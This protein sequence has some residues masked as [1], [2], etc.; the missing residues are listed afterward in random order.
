MKK[1]VILLLLIIPVAYAQGITLGLRTYSPFF[2]SLLVLILLAA[3]TFL[4]IFI[5]DHLPKIKFAKLNFKKKKIKARVKE[6]IQEL[7]ETDYHKESLI[8]AKKLNTLSNETALKQLSGLIKEYT[9][10]IL[11]IKHEVTHEE[12]VKAVEKNKPQLKD[13]LS[14]ILEYKY[15]GEN[16]TKEE[17]KDLSDRFLEITKSS[18]PISVEKPEP[19]IE[20]IKQMLI[21]KQ[22]NFKEFLRLINEK[23]KPIKETPKSSKKQIQRFKL[24]FEEE[25]P[26]LLQFF[27]P[28]NIYFQK[29]K[30]NGLIQKA[31]K[32]LHQVP[33][34]KK[35][36]SQALMLYYQL[37][38]EQEKE[39]GITLV[40][41]YSKIE[42]EQ[43]DQESRKLEL[44]TSQL[45]QVT[46]K[47]GV[48]T[49][50][51]KHYLT[52]IRDSLSLFSNYKNQWL[53]NIHQAT[54]PHV[55]QIEHKWAHNIHD[56]E[57]QVANNIKNQIVRV[58][59]FKQKTHK[60][61][62][63]IKEILT[64]QTL[65]EK[66]K[67]KE[68]LF[69]IKNKLETLQKN[70]EKR[71]HIKFN[72]KLQKGKEKEQ[73]K[74][75][76]LKYPTLHEQKTLEKIHNSLEELKESFELYFYRLKG[77]EIKLIHRLQDLIQE[78]RIK[79][80]K[81]ACLL[82]KS[83]L[84]LLDKIQTRLQPTLLKPEKI[85][86]PEFKKSETL[87][88]H[89]NELVKSVNK[90]KEHGSHKIHE[91]EPVIK[92]SLCQM[93][94]IAKARGAPISDRLM[95]VDELVIAPIKKITLLQNKLL[96]KQ[97]LSLVSKM[98]N[99]ENLRRQQQM[100][101]AL[102]KIE[103]PKLKINAGLPKFEPKTS[104]KTIDLNKQELEIQEKMNKLE[105]MGF[106]LQ[107]DQII[108]EFHK[109]KVK[110]PADYSWIEKTAEIR[111]KKTS[112]FKKLNKEEKL[113]FNQLNNLT[114]SS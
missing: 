66:T 2:I 59:E 105:Q 60:T 27:S 100:K 12:L 38:V 79:E 101:M 47:G 85:K 17:I 104:P 91:Q 43:L 63:K 30:L 86:L 28:L 9:Y 11:E 113:L 54:I 95:S 23:L 21:G 89:L 5:K 99:L 37:P 36:Y 29:K 80:K 48:I 94:D 96:E 110:E 65:K 40:S 71:K 19:K 93:I 74:I 34:A 84:D 41:L 75:E 76:E 88:N 97:E 1:E 82:H 69:S 3:I 31:T 70:Y 111:L 24:K 64:K 33:E 25:R 107:K 102:K 114:L 108:Q 72:I 61:E 50:E 49:K 78:I 67:V 44:I 103:K 106:R 42:Q 15:S 22:Q 73:L 14:K 58:K 55:T 52:K 8:F 20:A 109:V 83:E 18:K 39:Y 56:K 46:D 53:H 112:K 32:D 68:Q 6:E 62:E 92:A 35:L 10:S 81:G 98:A 45:N 16:Y 7:P 90:I 87:T 26:K 51:E 77:S 4:I 57:K 13:I